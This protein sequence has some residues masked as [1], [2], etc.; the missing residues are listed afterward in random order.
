MESTFER[1]T[2]GVKARELGWLRAATAVAVVLVVGVDPVVR[3]CLLTMLGGL[4]TADRFREDC[5]LGAGRG[6]LLRCTA[7]VDVVRFGIGSVTR[8]DV[9]GG[10]GGS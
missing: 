3:V 7:G 5:A 6:S 8:E 1:S 2:R 10:A 9:R 4:L